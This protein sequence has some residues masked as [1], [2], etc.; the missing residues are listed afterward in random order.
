M[1]YNANERCRR[2]PCEPLLDLTSPST[3]SIQTA[4]EYGGVPEW[5]KGTDCK[6]AAYRFDGSNPSSPTRKKT[7]RL[8][9]LFS[10]LWRR[11]RKAKCSAGKR[12]RRGLDRAEPLFSFVATKENANESVLPFW[13]LAINLVRPRQANPSSF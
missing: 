7:H 8:V 11:I 5:P 3:G 13:T 6:S 1:K 9:C 2:A 10:A 4:T 12:C